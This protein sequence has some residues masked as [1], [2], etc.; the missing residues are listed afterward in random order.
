MTD[1]IEY[2]P[3]IARLMAEHKRRHQIQKATYRL[4]QVAK[5]ASHGEAT[6]LTTAAPPQNDDDDGAGPSIARQPPVSDEEPPEKLLKRLTSIVEDRYCRIFPIP[7]SLQLYI[8]FTQTPTLSSVRMVPWIIEA[9]L[10]SVELLEAILK[11]SHPFEI[12]TARHFRRGCIQE[13]RRHTSLSVS[14]KLYAEYARLEGRLELE[15]DVSFICVPQ[16]AVYTIQRKLHGLFTPV[17]LHYIS[18]PWARDNRPLDLMHPWAM[19]LHKKPL[20]LPHTYE[21]RLKNLL[22]GLGVS[23]TRFTRS[24]LKHGT[25][26]IPEC[27]F[28][29]YVGREGATQAM[30][31]FASAEEVERNR[32]EVNESVRNEKSHGGQAG[33]LC[34]CCLPTVK[35]PC[36]R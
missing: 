16:Q 32:R 17:K 9:P 23:D 24:L 18:I 30:P 4:Q 19:V 8:P 22:S 11:P 6:D 2:D 34:E 33:I 20:I 36:G 29:W 10:N 14:K 21:N 12:Y 28:D 27:L 35:Y 5:A 3:T 1:N 31:Y 13:P 15:R 26:P 25:V 7:S